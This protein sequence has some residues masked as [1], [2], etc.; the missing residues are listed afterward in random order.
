MLIID[1]YK[2][3]LSTMLHPSTVTKKRMT[4]TEGLLYYIKGTAI[5]FALLILCII[6]SQ[7]VFHAKVTF[8]NG[9]GPL[10]GLA[11]NLA[12]YG[13][14]G[15]VLAIILIV[16]FDLYIY[17]GTGML[18]LAAIVYI[19][20]KVFVKHF[21]GSY[22]STFSGIVYGVTAAFA[23]IWFLAVALLIGGIM[24]SEVTAFPLSLVGF[25]G[26]LWGFVVTIKAVAV[27]DDMPEYIS[28]LFLIAIIV[29]LLLSG[30][31]HLSVS[32]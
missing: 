32:L 23:L 3:V 22:T 31:A 26:L 19:L 2:R 21:K 25:L 5:P 8:S 7:F 20:G 6:A 15:I 4:L 1:D 17:V 18:I 16:G 14:T 30:Q 12:T 11:V 29:A 10:A 27:Q 13:S 28:A 9:I 24:N